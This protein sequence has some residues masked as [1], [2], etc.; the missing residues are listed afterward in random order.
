VDVVPYQLSIRTLP[1]RERTT[2]LL[3]QEGAPPGLRSVGRK[4]SRSGLTLLAV[5]VGSLTFAAA[6]HAAIDDSSTSADPAAA[7]PATT[8]VPAAP[9]PA[10]AIDSAQ[11]PAPTAGEN[12]AENL[13]SVQYQPP[14]GADPASSQPAETDTGSATENTPDSAAAQQVNT[15]AAATSTSA[16]GLLITDA[17]P[18]PASQ[19]AGSTGADE[20]APAAPTS[21]SADPQ[22]QPQWYRPSNS[23]YQFHQSINQEGALASNQTGSATSAENTLKAAAVVAVNPQQ[24]PN[25]NLVDKPQ[26]TGQTGAAVSATMLLEAQP[27]RGALAADCG[28]ASA[29]YH[30]AEPQY[31]STPVEPD[32]AENVIVTLS[33]AAQQRA[34]QGTGVAGSLPSVPRPVPKPDAAPAKHSR[35]SVST[36]RA[37]VTGTLALLATPGPADVLVGARAAKVARAVGAQLL[38]RL[39]LPSIPRP[40]ALPPDVAGGHLAN[41]RRLLQIGLAL[42]IAYLLFLTFWF[43]RTRGRNRRLRGGTRL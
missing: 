40:H 35:A 30:A 6:A 8:S 20:P 13:V 1:A 4:R 14:D 39:R 10:S 11:A 27:C 41:T 9:A 21:P 29:R 3:G 2:S 24:V 25:S 26:D 22:P 36:A 7:P 33:Q 34:L 43:W 23:Q 42:G 16:S 38:P 37:A 15:P 32:A 18:A 12:S 28:T 5:A 19:A 31:P 17:A